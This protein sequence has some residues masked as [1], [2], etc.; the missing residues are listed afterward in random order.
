[1]IRETWAERVEP[2][3]EGNEGTLYALMTEAL[4]AIPEERGI[5]SGEEIKS[6]IRGFEAPRPE[7][8]AHL[9]ARAWVDDDF[10]RRLLANGREAAAELGYSIKEAQ[11]VVVENTPVVHNLIVCTPIAS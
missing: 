4:S 11:L 7:W 5:L 9:V 8:G 3:R 6:F 2:V 10:R 1:M